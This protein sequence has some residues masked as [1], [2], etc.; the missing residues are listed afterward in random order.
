M[1]FVCR[2]IIYFIRQKPHVQIFLSC[3]CCE[4]AMRKTTTTATTTLR[5]LEPLVLN[6]TGLRETL[7]PE[8]IYDAHLKSFKSLTKYVIVIHCL[9]FSLKPY[10]AVASWI[11]FEAFHY[12][13]I[14]C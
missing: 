13:K 6:K 3:T 10:F 14:F 9:I 11:C 7:Y 4:G 8:S 5:V 12:L 1:V 2:F